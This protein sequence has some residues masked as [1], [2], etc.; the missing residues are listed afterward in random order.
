MSVQKRFC[1]FFF[2]TYCTLPKGALK[3][4]ILSNMKRVSQ[5]SYEQIYG[6]PSFC[7]ELMRVL[8][9]GGVAVKKGKGYQSCN[10]KENLFRFVYLFKNM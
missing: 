1:Y 5:V 9:K 8:K 6:V 4:I 2:A 7:L 10:C 3:A